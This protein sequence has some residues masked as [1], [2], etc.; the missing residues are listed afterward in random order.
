MLNIA[1]SKWLTPS[2]INRLETFHDCLMEGG[3]LLIRSRFKPIAIIKKKKPILSKV[4][5]AL[6]KF[7]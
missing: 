7:K 2:S 3:V 1:I 6:G 5:I 4:K